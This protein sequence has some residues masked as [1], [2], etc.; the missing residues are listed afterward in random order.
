MSGAGFFCFATP[1]YAK[2]EGG[3]KEQR[4]GEVNEG[5]S[6]GK[7]LLQNQ[8][9]VEVEMVVAVKQARN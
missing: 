1:V 3:T 8:A 2:I 5:I 6:S 7:R 9:K 4:S